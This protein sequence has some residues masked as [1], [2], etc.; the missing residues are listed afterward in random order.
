MRIT[1]DGDSVEIAGQSG[2]SRE[3]VNIATHLMPEWLRLFAAKNADYGDGAKVLGVRG[4]YADINRKM[5]KLKRSLW[6]GDQLQFEDSDEVIMDLIGHLFLTLDMIR[7]KEETDRSHAFSGLNTSEFVERFIAELGGPAEALRVSA[8]LSEALSSRVTNRCHE[9]LGDNIVIS[10]WMPDKRVSVAE[11]MAGEQFAQAD[12]EQSGSGIRMGGVTNLKF[13]AVGEVTHPEMAAD[14]RPGE[15]T[16]RAMGGR[17]GF[18]LQ[19]PEAEAEAARNGSAEGYPDE[20]AAS[21]YA[22]DEG[23]SAPT[24]LDLIDQ[25]NKLADEQRR[26]ATQMYKMTR[27]L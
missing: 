11:R 7:F 13:E 3:L 27:G 19:S 2:D 14:G 23:F 8:T 16:L 20:A 12:F 26:I 25:S 5:L 10:A 15:A 4:Q 18:R 22:D 6:D 17:L 9:M 1:P 21:A 24:L